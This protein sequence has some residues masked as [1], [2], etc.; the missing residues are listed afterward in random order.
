[1]KLVN[2]VSGKQEQLG[3]HMEPGVLPVAALNRR[4]ASGQEGESLPLTLDELFRDETAFPRLHTAWN[5][6]IE[7]LGKTTEF[8]Y[9]FR[10]FILP[11]SEL[12]FAPV[13]PR[14]AKILCIG[15]NYRS[16]ASE[17]NISA[18]KS[19]IVFSKF[20]NALA[21]H[22][23]DIPLPKN[24]G[25]IDYE[26]ELA[27]VMGK[28]AESVSRE[29]ALDYVFG[30]CNSNDVSARDV[31]FKTSQ[32]LLGKT[33]EKFAPLGPYLVTADEVGDPNQLAIRTFVNGEIR[34]DSNTSDMI[35]YVRDLVHEISQ[36]MPL[37]PGDVILTG[38]PEGVI[39]GQAEQSRVWLK[40][41]DEVTIEIE[42]L[43]RL[44]NTFRK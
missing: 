16:H 31:Q 40:D 1:M 11:E 29:A 20:G 33:C 41:G 2:F 25:Q 14:N 17:T 44:T 15:I 8:A 4:V 9:Q 21:G 19:P 7:S 38:T 3:I 34:Q 27:V 6:T 23:E 18:A 32:W 42:K 22:K 28:R 5:R 43:G 37:E 24:S 13:V 36:Y 35:F 26:G 10:D 12:R 30:Y 39:L